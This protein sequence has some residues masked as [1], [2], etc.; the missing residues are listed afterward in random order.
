ML[1]IDGALA[2]PNISYEP[3]IIVCGI[4]PQPL[5][6]IFAGLKTS[7]KEITDK[8]IKTLK[9]GSFNTGKKGNHKSQYNTTILRVKAVM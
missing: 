6:D 8:I 5:E 3:S 2:N 1:Y 7:N 4:G 9:P